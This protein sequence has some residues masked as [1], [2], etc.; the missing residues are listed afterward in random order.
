M[1]CPAPDATPSS[2][3]RTVVRALLGSLLLIG[4][5]TYAF[6]A[7]APSGR[8]LQIDPRNPDAYPTL[9]AAARQ[10]LPG[11][12]L[13]IAPGSGPYREELFLPRSGTVGSPI[14]VEG[15]G[16]EIT[17]FDPIVFSAASP[18][19]PRSAVVQTPPPFVLRHH[20]IRLREDPNTG[21]FIA[22]TSTSAITYDPATRVLTLAPGASP[23]DWEI[24]SR[25][26]VVRIENT[27]H[28]HYRNIVATGALNDGFNLHGRGE[29]LVFE[30]ITACHNLDEGFSA[31]GD[32]S[33]EINGARLFG[34]DNGLVNI[35]RSR[36]LL[37]DV[38][39]WD[40][41]GIGLELHHEATISADNLV[42]WGNG[43]RQFSLIGP[44]TSVTGTGILIHR[45]HHA[46]RP[47]LTHKE[48]AKQTSP[49]ATLVGDSS[50][51]LATSG[52]LRVLDTPA[53]FT[54]AIR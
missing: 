35:Q 16:N 18:D 48:S 3:A 14:T 44:D 42:V 6:A 53:P 39:I 43:L 8:W 13:W 21:N 31:H 12:T 4:S 50:R 26:F 9:A 30:N 49:P 41:L 51:A 15:N 1:P 32:I 46:T 20:G 36:T 37:R 52:V 17:G 27:S 28:H 7:N 54:P 38:R 11:D 45:N 22:P 2:T 40:N 19:S 24:S 10:A 33:C 25:V 34:N 47:W 29:E 23:D 5:A